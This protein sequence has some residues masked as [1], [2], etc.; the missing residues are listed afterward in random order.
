MKVLHFIVP[1]AALLL[2]ASVQASAA[3]DGNDHGRQNA[4]SNNND[5]EPS[6]EEREA[7]ANPKTWNPTCPPLLHK[8]LKHRSQLRDQ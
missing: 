5:F 6:V 8:S 1:A 4:G 7:C 2:S 3:N